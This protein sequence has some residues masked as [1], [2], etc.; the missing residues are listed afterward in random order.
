[1]SKNVGSAESILNND[2]DD[3]R[4]IMNMKTFD[5]R[6]RLK[7]V[8]DGVVQPA[9]RQDSLMLCQQL[10][11]QD[12]FDFMDQS[13]DL[14]PYLRDL[15]GI[16]DSSEDLEPI[17]DKQRI[18]EY[19]IRMQHS[20]CGCVN[21]YADLTSIAEAIKSDTSLDDALVA[22]PE[23]SGFAV[24]FQ[25]V[26]TEITS[27]EEVKR[28]RETRLASSGKKDTSEQIEISFTPTIK[29]RKYSLKPEAEKK[30]PLYRLKREK[31]NDAVRRSRT[32]AKQQQKMKDEQIKQLQCQVTEFGKAVN[33][34]DEQIVHLENAIH[35][36][37]EENRHLRV[38]NM[39][40]KSEL[41]QAKKRCSARTV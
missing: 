11:E 19:D 39:R 9:D 35:E 20:V 4:H 10:Q 14:T 37:K 21:Q 24:T 40:L 29:P 38:E 16:D 13:M 22:V 31:N 26:K 36:V 23:T 12:G 2:I 6:N 27:G 32:K 17:I 34:K 30:N 8:T 33:V 7:T 18:L 1:M 3:G 41:N 15:R 28:T 25:P 5:G